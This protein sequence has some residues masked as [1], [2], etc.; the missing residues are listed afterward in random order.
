M[1]YHL[2]FSVIHPAVSGSRASANSCCSRLWAVPAPQGQQASASA[3]TARQLAAARGHGSARMVPDSVVW[4][5]GRRSQKRR[6]SADRW[7]HGACTNPRPPRG[8]ATL[9]EHT[10]HVSALLGMSTQHQTRWW[11]IWH[12]MVK[13]RCLSASVADLWGAHDEQNIVALVASALWPS[14]SCQLPPATMLHCSRAA[15]WK[16]EMCAI[17]APGGIA[18]ACTCELSSRYYT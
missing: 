4:E 18:P 11:Q 6:L 7:P 2:L 8:A 13:G 10:S 9:D 5:E 15:T 16:P 1:A 14:A 3:A 12:Q 17:L